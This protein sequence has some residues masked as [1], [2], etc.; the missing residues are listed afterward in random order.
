MGSTLQLNRLFKLIFLSGIFGISVQAKAVNV[1]PVPL[2]LSSGGQANVL[3]ILDN[4]NSMDEAANGSA[5]GSN[6][7]DSKS[8][9]S[10]DV[11]ET[12]I[13]TYTGQIN[14]GLM[15]YKQAN[16]SESFLHNS[17][18]DVSYNP[19]HEDVNWA[20]AINSSNHKKYKIP[21]PADPGDFVYY[22]IALPFYSDSNQG[23]LF[24]Y[25]PTANAFNNGEDPTWPG[26]SPNWDQYWCF[27][28]KTG[29]DNAVFG[30]PGVNNP[31][32][33]YGGYQYRS[34][35][36]PTDS[37]L[38][39][40][41]L[42]FGTQ[43]MWTYVDRA[44]LSNES[45]GR[46]FLH[47]PIKPLDEDQV[48][49]LKNKLKCSIPGQPAPCNVSGIQ[50]A[51]L[52]PIEG[53]LL[54]AKD[55]FLGGW[56]DATEG[57]VESCYPLPTSCGKDFV[58]LLT[59]GMPSTNKDGDTIATPAT[60]IEEAASAAAVLKAAGIETYVVGFALPNGVDPATLNT[61]ADAGGTNTAFVATDAT[62]LTSA[63]KSIFD[64]ID[65]KT[66]SAA[67]IATNSTRLD[68]ETV[69]FQAKFSS[70][71]WSGQLLAYS[72]DQNGA[73]VTPEV[74]T[75][76]TASTFASAG[77]RSVFTFQSGT[78][79]VPF[80]WDSLD[81]GQKGYLN[82]AP[83]GVTADALG[84]DR[85]TWL[86]GDDVT[87]MRTRAK[88]LGDII[89]ADPVYIRAQDF[90]Y[91]A[92]SDE[93]DASTYMTYMLEKIT[94]PTSHPS[95]LYVGAND[96]MLHAFDAST[97]VEKFAYIPN[98]LMPK[99]SKLMASDYS[100]QYFV[101]AAPGFGDARIDTGDGL[102]LR[103]RTV[104]VGGLG[105]GGKGIYALDVTFPN[106][107]TEDN[108]L[109]EFTHAELGDLSGTP[110]IVSSPEGWVAIFGNGYNSSSGKAKL[111][112][113]K[114]APDLDDGWTEDSD[115]WIVDTNASVA[116][117]LGT[118]AIYDADASRTI[119]NS[120]DDAIYA[121]DLLGNIWKF[122][123]KTGDWESA[124][125]T[126][127]NPVPLFKAT[128]GANAQPV[129]APLEI[130]ASPNGEGVMLYFGTGQYFAV[131]DAATTSIQSL[132]GIWDSGAAITTTN[133]SELVQQTI[134]AEANFTYVK[135]GDNITEKLRV[136]SKNPVTLN[137]GA[138][139]DVYGWFMDLKNPPYPAGTA[140]GERV[141][142][143]PLI[144]NNRA[145]FT[146]LVPSS[147]PCSS[148]GK[149]WLMEMSAGSGGAPTE[150]VLDINGDGNIDS[151]DVVTIEVD[152]ESVNVPPTG[153]LIESGI[154]KTPAVI[155]AGAKEYK[156]TSSTAAEIKIITE[157]GYS[158]NPRTSWHEIVEE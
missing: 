102:G 48:T 75:T 54:T 7:P 15:A 56:T 151:A 111:F 105:A 6:S 74:W 104:L 145:I 83:D 40:G 43:I 16:I 46:G 78:G 36:Y 96:G 140:A 67:A 126:G 148:G 88:L 25:S 143:A 99:L 137:D 131:G 127:A 68:S 91:S 117:G 28:T 26:N 115:Y 110:Q 132:Y 35:F 22:N 92:L 60:A 113:V 5:V 27:N 2:F 119:G 150:P 42:D 41:I 138:G 93:T 98:L 55:Y 135:D 84:A 142:S 47:T 121:G 136:T 158:Q 97:G 94:N 8:E 38:A 112:V 152:G 103:W 125:K 77:S 153:L 128:D 59:D 82:T 62:T 45:P 80:L 114:L 18:Y 79:G 124:Y 155:S 146:T 21:N 107:F 9:I 100:H 37:D 89:N 129:T 19:A 39:Q 141:V 156:I 20:G 133:R 3:V 120:S 149:S 157:S 31:G 95:M 123:Y 130:G 139:A 58:I 144:R 118:P 14:M 44:W 87:G 50:N 11:I 86:R 30:T 71:D 73:V 49:A 23:T 76:N 90:G 24:C 13:D 154:V 108:V 51:G 33:G 34:R 12:L 52:T 17:P 1:S 147:D 29:E 4:S 122:E 10:R 72:L 32:L 66:S 109:W 134:D 69:V 61:I 85:V 116:N 53:T 57:Y 81:A 106:S 65:K 63:L 101:D 64:D 70:V